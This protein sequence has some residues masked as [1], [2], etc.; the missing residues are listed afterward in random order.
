MTFDRG[1]VGLGFGGVWEGRAEGAR[2]CLG[3]AGPSPGAPPLQPQHTPP[4]PFLETWP[5]P[6]PVP[7]L[8]VGIDTRPVRSA[9][10]LLQALDD[11]RP[12]DRVRCDVLRDGKRLSMTVLLGER[13]P[14]AV[15]E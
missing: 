2:S 13:V 15:E 7:P 9:A 6:R 1:V 14:G 4:A 10:E 11:K 12:G 8:A 5:A 3:A